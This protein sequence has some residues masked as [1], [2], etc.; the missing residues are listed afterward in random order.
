[1]SFNQFTNLDFNSLRTQIKDYLRA[2][3]NFTDF[4]FEGSNFSVLID[5]LAY[6]SYI[7]AFNTNM[8]VNESFIDSATLRENVVSLARN[9]GY[10][11]RSKRSA[12]AIIN[13]SVNTSAFDTN[14]SIKTITL[15]SGVVA[16]GLVQSGSFIFSVPDDITVLVDENQNAYFNNIEIYEGSYLTKNFNVN[17]GTPNQKFIIP[18]PSVDSTTVRVRAI[19]NVTEEYQQFTNIF[20]VDSNTRMYLLQEV[21]DEK[22]QIVFGDNILGKKPENGAAIFVSYIVT[23]GASGNG[24]RNFS[25][26]GILK[27][28]NDNVITTGISLVTTIQASEN[29][30]DIEPLD[31]VKYLAPRVYA[32]Q[33]RAV[34]ANDYKSLIPFLFSNVE[35]VSAYGG[36]ELPTPEYGKVFISVKPK[37]GTYISKATKESILKQLKSYS[38]AGIKPELVNLKYLY[39]ELSSYVYYNKSKVSDLG[40]LRSSV[41]N[42]I[43]QYAKSSDL[44][45]FAARFKYSKMTSLIDNTSN[46]ITSNITTVKIRRNLFPVE[47]KNATYEICFGNR[48]HI[49]KTNSADGGGYNIKSTGFKIKDNSN[50]L[51]LGDTP[52]SD[53]EGVLFFFK[54][55]DKTPV[56]VVANVG[57]I[58]YLKGEIILN[59]VIFTSFDGTEIQIEAVPESNDVIGLREL[60]LQLNTTNLNVQMV[61]DTLASGYNLSGEDYAV[62]SSYTNGSFIR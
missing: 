14:K 28:N 43:T 50:T 27:D 60:Y 18:N 9:I 13:F 58:N 21:L 29:G 40:S 22:Y 30:D 51:Y 44:N 37:N 33:Y 1:M 41:I 48:F 17:S 24:A 23:N 26:S 16:L 39:I 34:S 25:F 55:V 4:D 6:N 49:K 35:S 62:S 46:G 57:K 47:N 31:N 8:A 38:I 2:N 19:T 11:P 53:T 7:T 10:V 36:E 42:T 45:I 56:N 32:S 61:E 20:K 3:S 59:S 5:T 54:M 15:K 12:R 52:T